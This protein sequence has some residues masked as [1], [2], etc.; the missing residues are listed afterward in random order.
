MMM[1][2]RENLQVV[3]WMLVV[4]FLLTI[5]LSW[6][7]GGADVLTTQG[8][9]GK[10]GSMEVRLQEFDQRVQTELDNF[11]NR[12]GESYPDNRMDQFR[13]QVWN[14]MVNQYVITQELEKRSI[15][16]TDSEFVYWAFNNPIPQIKNNPNFQEN[17]AFSPTKLLQIIQ[18]NQSLAYQLDYIHKQVYP[19]QTMQSLVGYSRVVSDAEVLENFRRENLKANV[20]YFGVSLA[21]IP[22][23]SIEVSDAEIETYYNDNIENFSRPEQRKIE[24]IR[25]DIEASRDDTVLVVDELEDIKNRIINKESTFAEEAKVESEDRVTAVNNG[26]TGLKAKGSYSS[27]FETLIYAAEKGQLVGPVEDNGRFVL[28]EIL[29]KKTGE[30]DSI[31]IRQIVKFIVPGSTT[32]TN[33]DDL[34]R[35]I[36]ERTNEG[37]S[38]RTIASENEL[39]YNETA[40]F[41]KSGNIPGIGQ[42]AYLTDFIFRKNVGDVSREVRK[43]QNQ[44]IFIVRIAD[45]RAEG[46]QPLEQIKGRIRN[47]V[48]NDKKGQKAMD[49]VKQARPKLETKSYAEVAALEVFRGMAQTDTTGFVA[50]YD[51]FMRPFGKSAD[52]V[53]FIM[54]NSSGKIS[55]PILT[56][57]GAFVVEVLRKTEMSNA[58]FEAQKQVL[59]SRL[60]NQTKFTEFDR[61]LAAAKQDYDIEVYRLF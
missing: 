20:R 25:I 34:A 1:K 59:R 22:S 2:I 53:K 35:E 32:I 33:F 18:Q 52:V 60:V 46:F 27:A 24:Y 10:I 5:W 6:G 12:T 23:S 26:E 48:L 17:G 16:P 28:A 56:Q 41:E 21:R 8:L 36:I 3:L 11:K 30:T 9:A 40:F 51:R 54:N 37:D 14:Q 29:E 42:D 19:S 38:L 49:L 55:E 13:E 61:W 43:N 39:F 44:T 31:N 50:F 57:T 7:A 15:T 45:A 58:E 4:A 47:L